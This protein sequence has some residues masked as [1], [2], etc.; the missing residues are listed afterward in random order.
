M[1]STS[2]TPSLVPIEEA[3]K[4]E[5]VIGLDPYMELYECSFKKDQEC[6]QRLMKTSFQFA[7]TNPYY[8][9][10]VGYIQGSLPYTFDEVK[11]IIRFLFD[12]GFD[13]NEDGYDEL[14]DPADYYKSFMNFFLR[15]QE[16]SITEKEKSNELFLNLLHSYPVIEKNRIVRNR[17]P[18]E[19]GNP[20]LFLLCK[21]HVHDLPLLYASEGQ[22]LD[23]LR[24]LLQVPGFDFDFVNEYGQDLLEFLQEIQ[25]KATT[26][27][28]TSFPN[29]VIDIVSER[30]F[31]ARTLESS[32]NA[33]PSYP[34]SASS[35]SSV[36]SRSRVLLRPQRPSKTSSYVSSTS[37]TLLGEKRGRDSTDSDVSVSKKP[38]FLTRMFMYFL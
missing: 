27:S 17:N 7:G 25:A 33:I 38:T 19:S 4:E 32:Y 9:L 22:L 36:P 3:Y 6:I 14:T 35:S 1:S 13:M 20:Y 23:F 16:K 11:Q 26:A 24:R 15:F 10:F 5:D 8:T 12:L 18:S 21:K 29:E 30:I 31:Q 2:F 37:S 28:I 34:Y